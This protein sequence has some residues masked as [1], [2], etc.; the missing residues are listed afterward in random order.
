MPKRQEFAK[1]I[2]ER[3]LEIEVPDR[4]EAARLAEKMAVKAEAVIAKLRELDL[5]EAEELDQDAACLVVEEFN[6]RPVRMRTAAEDLIKGD[7]G[8]GSEVVR[9]PPIVTVMGHVNHGKTTLLDQI[10]KA[11][12]AASEDGGI[13]QHIGSYQV[14]TEYGSVTMIDTP[15]HEVFSEMRARGANLTD[16]V[17][18]V[19][20]V[21]DGVQPQT[22]EAI[23][24][25]R[26]AKVE[27]VVALNKIDIPGADKSAILN[28]LAAQGI[29]T[30][31]LGGAVPVVEISA[32]HGQNIDGL[33]KEIIDIAEL[34]EFKAPVDVEPQG[35]VIEAKMEKGLGPV[36][37]AIVKEGRLRKGSYL[38]CDVAHGKVRELRDENGQVIKEAGPSTPVQIQ[39][40][41]DLPQ[42]GCDFYVTTEQRARDYVKEVRFRSQQHAHANSRTDRVEADSIQEMLRMAKEVEEKKVINLVLKADVA[43]TREAMLQALEKIGNDSAELKV[44]LSG[45]GPITESD[46]NMA[47]ASGALMVGFRVTANSK[48]RKLIEDRKLRTY[49]SDVF[50]E[51]TD[52]VRAQLEGMLQPVVN[53]EVRGAALVKEVF[54]I[55]KIGRIAGCGVTEGTIERKL[56]VRVVR[57]GT[58]VAKT[59]I[60]ELRHYK[61]QADSVKAGSDC[62]ICLERFADFKPGD[63]I[64][65]YEE[66]TSAQKL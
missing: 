36:A 53:E 29:E 51:V 22:L 44:V 39:G 7:R 31:A 47:A 20:A 59:K 35:T 61:D 25:A 14:Q 41:S 62:G 11:R 42:V 54:T 6:H 27:I 49:F 2:K 65:T 58:I 12:V 50:Y 38:I 26:D 13:T 64:E 17:V 57:D 18:L 3:I 5:D 4:I 48:A 28:E 56:P 23:A 34:H 45:L 9:R 30:T 33:L 16:I 55:H 10:R 40:L 43:G 32:L 60:A 8:T 63:L 24:H 37:T 46:V 1:P 21:D 15:G 19:V 52:F 66:I